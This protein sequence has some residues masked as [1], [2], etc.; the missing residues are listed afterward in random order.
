MNLKGRVRALERVR[1]KG[2]SGCRGER[3]IAVEYDDGPRAIPR[4]CPGCGRETSL[5][6][7]FSYDEAASQHGTT[8][9]M[10]LRHQT[11]VTVGG[12]PGAVLT[13]GQK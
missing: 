12:V 8:A 7:H 11:A 10:N 6:I 5:I 2:C 3:F 4:Y 13:K 1:G 9:P